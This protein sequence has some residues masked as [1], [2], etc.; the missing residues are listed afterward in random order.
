MVFW[1]NYTYKD[2]EK[3]ALV[4]NFEK[5]GWIRGTEG[6]ILIYRDD[7]NIYWA[8]VGNFRA[9]MSP[10]SGYRL[11]DSQYS[12]NLQESSIIFPIIW[13]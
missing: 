12:F 10:E 3:A 11:S 7:W 1:S 13:S 5:R 9:I 4:T 8:G 6:L 2:M